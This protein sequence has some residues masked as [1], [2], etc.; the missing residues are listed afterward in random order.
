MA[1]SNDIFNKGFDEGTQIKLYILHKYLQEWLPVFLKRRQKYWTDIS[2]YDMFA[3]EGKDSEGVNGS[4]LIMLEELFPYCKTIK[5]ESLRLNVLFNEVDKK[6]YEALKQN[7]SEKLME[8]KNSE[9]CP[10]TKDC[11]LKVYEENKDFKQLFGEWYPF[12]QNTAQL[13][14]FMFLDQFGIKQIT[15][16]I[17][18]QLV[19]LKRTDFI[20]FISS[21][22]ANRFAEQPEFQTYLKLNRESFDPTKPH[23]CHRV[24]FNYYKQLIPRGTEYYLAPF[25]IK[26]GPNIYGL[27][28]GTNHLLGIEKFLNI[29]WGI[30]KNTG[31]ANYDIDNEKI[32]PIEPSLWAEHDISNK[33]QVFQN[34]LKNKVLS[35]DLETN[36]EVYRWTF[37]MGCLPKHA[38]EVLRELRKQRTINKEFRIASSNIHKLVPEKLK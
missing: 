31:D 35:N 14:R 21:S 29:C 22:F 8:C 24:V 4:P 15:E 5:D 36:V 19:S 23:H 28:F 18:E 38:N 6:R 30:N 11:I 16:D 25:S 10:K 7:I 32:N 37:E 34:E 20:F 2:L 9:M 17:F 27:I 3:G 12:M 26:K 13:P 1:K 33:I